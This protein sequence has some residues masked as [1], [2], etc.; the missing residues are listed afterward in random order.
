MRR[1]LI[2]RLGDNLS[3]DRHRLSKASRLHQG[4]G[5]TGRVPGIMRVD[6][7]GTAVGFGAFLRIGAARDFT[8]SREQPGVLRICGDQFFQRRLGDLWIVGVGG[9][10]V[11]RASLDVKDSRQLGS[12]IDWLPERFINPP[13]FVFFPAS[14]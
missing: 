4:G 5:I 13:S 2:R 7:V 6:L 10:N 1:I 9:G 11:F 3:Q 12:R 14:S 8:E